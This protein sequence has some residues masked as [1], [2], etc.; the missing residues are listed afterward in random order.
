[1]R[2]GFGRARCLRNLCGFR[3]ADAH[4]ECMAR[5]AAAKSRGRAAGDAG[6]AGHC[7]QSDA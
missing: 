2:Y 5:A 6:D 1:M 3:F 4:R 7:G